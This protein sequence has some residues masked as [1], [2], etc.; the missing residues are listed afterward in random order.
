MPWIFLC[1]MAL[2]AAYFGWQFTQVSAPRTHVKEASLPQMGVRVELLSER[3]RQAAATPVM[4]QQAEAEPAPLVQQCFNVGPFAGEGVAR[5][6]ADTMRSKHFEAVI[7]KRKA[8]IKDYW[9]FIP[10]FTNR[11]R[12]EEKLRDLKARG[13]Q[14]FVVRDGAFI[15]AISLNHFSQKE[16]AQAFLAKM[17]EQGVSVEFREMNS[18][19]AELWAY[20]EPGRSK[21]SLRAGI[22]AYLGSH[23]ELRRESVPCQD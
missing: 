22:D 14:G 11:E 10:A 17:Q 2:N 5:G 15:N 12:A 4:E 3:P 16:L 7:N 18:M 21:A 9:V 8:E 6:F 20:V 23:E 13:V 1:L 19:G